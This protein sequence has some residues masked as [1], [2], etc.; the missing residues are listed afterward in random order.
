M[1]KHLR[2]LMLT[3]ASACFIHVNAQVPDSTI[4]VDIT[5]DAIVYVQVKLANAVPENDTNDIFN[6]GISLSQ[7]TIKAWG[8]A[9]TF[10][11]FS[12][13]ASNTQNPGSIIDVR[14][15]TEYSVMVEQVPFAKGDIFHIWLEVSYAAQTYNVYVQTETG[16]APVQIFTDAAFR[17][18]DPT[19]LK[20]LSSVRNVGESANPI[21]ILEY[22][23]TDQ[24]GLDEETALNFPKNNLTIELY[25]NPAQDIINLSIIENVAEVYIFDCT[26]RSVLFINDIQN[27]TI[28]ISNLE[29]G[30]YIVK[31]VLTD[32]QIA[33]Q[34]MIKK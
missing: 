25:P 28:N 27:N 2:L 26:G 12:N 33:S 8:D 14:N 7:D 3:I 11:R 23:L 1:K 21:E 4:T 19:S 16:D 32:G 13:A 10:V 29:Q 30:A 22:E 9:S 18:I 20:Y 31:L 34:P 17:K 5:D 6:S 15:G 24:I